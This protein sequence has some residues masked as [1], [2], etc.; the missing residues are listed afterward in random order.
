[1]VKLVVTFGFLIA[2]AAGLVVG[3][4]QHSI[5]PAAPPTTRPSGPR[6]F[7]PAALNLTADQQEKMKKIW[8]PSSGPNPREQRE[9]RDKCRTEREQAILALLTPEQKT[10]YDEIWKNYR[11]KNDSMDRELREDF[12]KKVEQTKEI[13]TPEQR[14]KYEELLAK[15]QPFD[16]GGPREHGDRG[17]FREPN[18]RGGDDHAT[19][20]P[21]SQP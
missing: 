8:D 21:H 5:A 3:M 19:S 14:T 17:G 18:R 16:R 4:Q 12:Q 6:G 9:R 11:D 2:F 7:L 20:K 15:R 13:L 1:M 10:Q